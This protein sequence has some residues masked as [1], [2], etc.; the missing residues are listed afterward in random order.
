MTNKMQKGCF[1]LAA[2]PIKKKGEI[3]LNKNEKQGTPI[4]IDL[5]QQGFKLYCLFGMEPMPF[6]CNGILL[7]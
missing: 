6:P 3:I 4:R 5:L 2:K 7:I 1:I